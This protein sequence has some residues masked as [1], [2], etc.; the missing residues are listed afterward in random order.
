VPAK[1]ERNRF[2]W[3]VWFAYIQ[4]GIQIRFSK[5]VVNFVAAKAPNFNKVQQSSTSK[6]QTIQ[7]E[8]LRI[9]RVLQGSTRF[10]IWFEPTITLECVVLPLKLDSQGLGI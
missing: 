8:S 1:Q 2:G 5:E 6:P 4:G 10:S 7:Q 9:H 3:N